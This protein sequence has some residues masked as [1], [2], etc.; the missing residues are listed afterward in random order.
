[1]EAIVAC[2]EEKPKCSISDYGAEAEYQEFSARNRNGLRLVAEPYDDEKGT[3]LSMS[4]DAGDFR[5]WLLQEE[6]SMNVELQTPEVLVDRHS[7]D[8]WLGLVY[9]GRDIVL[10]VFL[11]LITCYLYDKIKGAL[12]GDRSQIH[13]TVVYTDSKDGTCKKLVFDGDVDSVKNLVESLRRD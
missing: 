4:A 10:P 8:I 13:L 11:G 9:I 1:M 3:R 5:K 12:R 6:P 2:P 7:G